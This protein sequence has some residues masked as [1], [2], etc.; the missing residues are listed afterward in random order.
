M[1]IYYTCV[2]K[3]KKILHNEQRC[4]NIEQ[5]NIDCAMDRVRNNGALTRSF[6]KCSERTYKLSQYLFDR[7]NESISYFI[8]NRRSLTH[9]LKYTP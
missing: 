6:T 7:T 1:R 3:D 4:I 2:I 8:I 9:F 5:F